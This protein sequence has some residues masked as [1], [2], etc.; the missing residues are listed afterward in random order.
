MN[1]RNSSS[2]IFFLLVFTTPINEK[3][4]VCYSNLWKT[5]KNTIFLLIDI[6]PLILSVAMVILINLS[7][8]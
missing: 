1:T 8:I 6:L 3:S 2:L 4:A 7:H 5:T